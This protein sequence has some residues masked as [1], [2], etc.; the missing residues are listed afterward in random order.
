M[1]HLHAAPSRKKAGSVITMAAAAAFGLFP[2]GLSAGQ[3]AAPPQQDLDQVM[4]DNH[5]DASLAAGIKHRNIEVS[6]SPLSSYP[7]ENESYTYPS[8]DASGVCQV[9]VA[10][11]AFT[12]EDMIFKYTSIPKKYI[13]D[14]H[15]DA[16]LTFAR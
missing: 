14:F 7:F 12:R 10:N 3:T 13:R 6:V 2:S 8:E 15:G 11:P 9:H 4:K 5:L 1:I 16:D